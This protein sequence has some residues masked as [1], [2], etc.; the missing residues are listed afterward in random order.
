MWKCSRERKEEHMKCGG[1]ENKMNWEDRVRALEAEGLTRSD[2]QAVVDAE[3]LNSI[4]PGDRVTILV[5]AG[6][7]RYGQ[8]WKPKTGRAVMR[9]PA[10]WVLNMGGP[11][12]TPGIATPE[13]IRKVVPH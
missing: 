9:G 12:G 7:G 5:P 1:E 8:E 6:I 11:H 10:G 2:A 13:N 3:V 4:K